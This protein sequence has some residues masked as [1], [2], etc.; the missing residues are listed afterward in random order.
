MITVIH[1]AEANMPAVLKIENEAISP[2]WSEGALLNEVGREDGL[3]ALA[4]EDDAVLGFCI[5]R[6]AADEAELYQIAVRQDCRR[7]GIA[8]LLLDAAKNTAWRRISCRFILK[9]GEATRQRS[10]CIKNTALKTKAAVKTTTV[11]LSRTR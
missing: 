5:V 7:R 2:P 1:A 4:A 9:S 3:F 10:D 8:D 6:C 11:A